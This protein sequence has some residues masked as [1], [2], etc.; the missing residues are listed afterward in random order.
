MD[1]NVKKNIYFKALTP[2]DKEI[3]ITNAYWDKLI[4]KTPKRRN[5]KEKIGCE[6]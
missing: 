2:L 5:T 6:S 1:K 4:K 3:R